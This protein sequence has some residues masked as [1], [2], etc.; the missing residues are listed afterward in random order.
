MVSNDDQP[1]GPVPTGPRSWSAPEAGTAGTPATSAYAPGGPAYGRGANQPAGQPGAQ[2]PWGAPGSQQP[3]QWGGARPGQQAGGQSPY[4]P[5]PYGQPSAGPY[6][7]A[8]TGSY[9]QPPAAPPEG[10]GQPP[11]KRRRSPWLV[12]VA[13]LAL[14][15]IVAALVAG[16]RNSGNDDA[17]GEGAG[18]TTSQ[19]DDDAGNSRAGDPVV[20]S[21][22]QN[23]D[24]AAVAE[25]V[26]PSVVAI[27][28]NS[29]SG[30][31]AGSGVVIDADGHVVTNEHVV[32]GG[33]QIVVTLS[34]GRMFEAS[35]VGADVA[36]DL[37]V[38]ALDNPPD[39][40]VPATFGDSDDVVVGQSVAAVGNP[41]GLSSTLTTGVVSA[42]DRP[43]STLAQQDGRFGQQQAVQ[44]VTNAIQVDAAINPGNSGGPLFDS[45]GRVIGIN[46]SIASLSQSQD[47]AGSIGLGFAIPSNL[48]SS[49]A[50]QLLADGVAEHSFLGVTMTDATATADGVTRAGAQVRSVEPGSPAEEAGLEVGDVITFINGE[51]IDGATSLTGWVRQMSAGETVDLSVVRGGQALEVQ[52]TLTTR[53]DDLG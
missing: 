19:Q 42:L 26:G 13:L 47:V 1:T 36:T 9:G 53:E 2:A 12:L 39:D 32:S 25:A 48:A 28:V 5:A 24:W 52:T 31:G 4:A 37:A 8:S 10:G 38:L 41:L 33:E 18:A 17:D 11:R 50:D 45:T 29:Q 3:Y 21:T 46:S 14:L 44:V 15:A 30:T 27:T 22:S 20:T 6:G 7:H 34:D 16:L 40:L 35:V 23:P 43:V 49:I 51:P